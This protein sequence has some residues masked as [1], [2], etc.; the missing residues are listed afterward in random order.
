MA[1]DYSLQ[2]VAAL[3]DC[4]DTAFFQECAA[5]YAVAQPTFRKIENVLVKKQSRIALTVVG[6]K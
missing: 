5:S 2:I 4:F 3:V 6:L 1:A